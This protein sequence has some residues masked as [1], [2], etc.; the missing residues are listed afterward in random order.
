MKFNEHMDH[1]HRREE[2]EF[3]SIIRNTWFMFVMKIIYIYIYLFEVL[4]NI[5]IFLI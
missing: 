4:N 3:D 2:E 5:C 1:L